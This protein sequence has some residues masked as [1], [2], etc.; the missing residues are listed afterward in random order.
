[1]ERKTEKLNSQATE[2][3]SRLTLAL[4]RSFLVSAVLTCYCDSFVSLEGTK[5]SRSC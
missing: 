3:A 1:M 4:P 5:G 2:L